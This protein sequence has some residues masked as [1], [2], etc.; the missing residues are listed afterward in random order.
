[1]LLQSGVSIS[2]LSRTTGISVVT[3]GS[4]KGQSQSRHFQKITVVGP[5]PSHS[6]R[7]RLYITETV[8]LELDEA[9]ISTGILQKIRAAL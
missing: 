4:W 7:F 1:M 8:W 2:T 9:S 5:E 6:S 3:L